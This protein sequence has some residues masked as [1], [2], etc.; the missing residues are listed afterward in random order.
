[1]DSDRRREATERK[2]E[3]INRR[4]RH[5]AYLIADLDLRIVIP[6]LSELTSMFS[7]A[8][9]PRKEGLC[10]RVWVDFAP[11]PAYPAQARLTVGMAPNPSAETLRVTVSVVL[12]PVYLNY[13]HE[14]WMD[15][16]VESP[17][18]KALEEFLDKRFVQFVKD[19]L[20]TGTPESPYHENDKVTD[21]VC[22]MS[23]PPTEAADSLEYKGR[24]Y[25]FCVEG[26]RRKFE[27][28]PERYVPHPTSIKDLAP[29]E[30][31]PLLEATPAQIPRESS[32]RTRDR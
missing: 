16:R 25:Y 13:E 29:G 1:M 20:R 6:R 12:V 14:A 3:E 31:S 15:L 30:R 2:M 22:Q 7:N 28:A 26:C 17:D 18:T 5:V 23:F 21:P 27:T 9:P 11:T 19:Y 8:K 4:L 10:D 24:L 32:L